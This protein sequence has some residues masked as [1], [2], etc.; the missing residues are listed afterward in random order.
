[1]SKII[2]IGIDPTNIWDNNFFREYVKTLVYDVDNYDVYIV[3]TNSDVNF[4]SNVQIESNVSIANINQV[5]NNSAVVARLNT[6]GVLIYLSEDNVLVNLINNT[7]PIQLNSNNV[8]GCQALVLNNILDIYLSQPKW[9][10]KV[11]FWQK[12]ILDQYA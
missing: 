10:T 11:D 8:L 1:M 5:S 2:K 4:L 7:L 3:T 6:L 12:Q 9:I